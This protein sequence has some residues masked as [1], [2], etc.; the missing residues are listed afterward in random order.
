MTRK[1]MILVDAANQTAV[2]H[3]EFAEQGIRLVKRRLVG[4]V[5]DGVDILE[6]NNGS[7]AMTIL[8][9]RG[10]GIW[11]GRCGEV[12]FEWA[13]PVQGPV[14]PSLVPLACDSGLG[15]LYGFDEWLVRCGLESNGSPQSNERGGLVYPLHGQIANIPA[16]YVEV[17]FD[18]DTGEIIVEGTVYE[19]R[20]FSKKLE[21][22]V[23][24][25][26]KVGE[27]GF[28]MR[29]TVT[30][31]SA[32]AKEIVLLYHINTGLPFLGKGSRAVVPFEMQAPRSPAAAADLSQ[33]D[34]LDPHPPGREETVYF[35]DPAANADGNTEVML[36][37]GSE[38][39]GIVFGFNKQQLPCFSLWKSRLPEQDGYVVGVEPA[40]NYPNTTAF[41]SQH[42]RTVPLAAGQSQA[43]DLS[44]AFLQT[45]SEVAYAEQRI[46]ERHA[47][48]AGTVFAD[49]R[50]E[51]SE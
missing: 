4:G 38:E 47:T 49:P 2:D 23:C 15:W 16:S 14:H 41:E 6:V 22:K 29:D 45:K 25:V 10:M 11:R 31:L 30:N 3:W 51:W 43:F 5:S 7:F 28:R 19:S 27:P 48:A 20:L 40:T 44:F 36:I 8:L 24:Y 26:I 18:S 46:R 17:S 37:N 9:S 42:G 34:C 50:A 13:S 32:S 1:S 39:Q 12:H 33:W 35:F 21:M